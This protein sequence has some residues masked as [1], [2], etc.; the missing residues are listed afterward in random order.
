MVDKILF[1]SDKIS[2]ELSG[3]HPH[4]TEMRRNTYEINIDKA[5]L[6]YLD[7]IWEQKDKLKLIHPWLIKA[8]EELLMRVIR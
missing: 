2:W 7:S 6:I 4:L 8:R 3:E 5:I 1:V